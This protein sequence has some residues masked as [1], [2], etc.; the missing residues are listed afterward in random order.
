[1]LTSFQDRKAAKNA[2]LASRRNA[3]SPIIINSGSIYNRSVVN[4]SGHGVGHGI[5]K[6]STGNFI[7]FYLPFL[8]SRYF[9]LTIVLM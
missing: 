9:S 3:T 1:M 2:C 4:L 8:S 6:N 5:G 7:S